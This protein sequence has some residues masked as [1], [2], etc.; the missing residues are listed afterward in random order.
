MLC[1]V[2][3]LSMDWDRVDDALSSG[4]NFRPPP[5]FSARA[6]AG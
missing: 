3:D 2:I 4:K 6:Q 1:F 5:T